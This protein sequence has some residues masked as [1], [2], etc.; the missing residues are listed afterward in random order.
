MDLRKL[1]RESPLAGMIINQNSSPIPVGAFGENRGQ[2]LA[3]PGRQRWFAAWADVCSGV[4]DHAESE[5]DAQDFCDGFQCV[6]LEAWA[7]AV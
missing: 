3:I 6:S 2:L 7:F 5:F 1:L 4:A